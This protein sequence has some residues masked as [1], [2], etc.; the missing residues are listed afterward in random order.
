VPATLAR[1]RARPATG[2]RGASAPTPPP[3]TT[4]RGPPPGASTGRGGGRGRRVPAPTTPATAGP[5][6]ARGGTRF[7]AGRGVAPIPTLRLVP[8][9]RGPRPGI[10]RSQAGPSTTARGS[11]HWT[12]VGIVTAGG[13][14]T[15]RGGTAIPAGGSDRIARGDTLSSAPG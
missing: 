6:T 3:A 12:R 8:S 15:A 4:T 9:L 7:H 11:A 13:S 10:T 1:T 14:R 2:G 5:R